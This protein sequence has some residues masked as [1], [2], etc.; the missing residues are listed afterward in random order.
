MNV[1]RWLGRMAVMAAAMLTAQGIP[2]LHAEPAASDFTGLE[3]SFYSQYGEAAIENIGLSGLS[4]D[5][6]GGKRI[7]LSTLA[8]V[9]DLQNAELTPTVLRGLKEG[10]LK[11]QTYHAVLTDENGIIA[12]YVLLRCDYYTKNSEFIQRR[13]NEDSGF[14]QYFDKEIADRFEIIT[15]KLTTGSSFDYRRNAQGLLSAAAG[16]NLAAGKTKARLVN[17][18][19]G[20]GYAILLTDGERDYLYLLDDT[21][22]MQEQGLAAK[23]I[24]SLQALTVTLSQNQGARSAW[25]EPLLGGAEPQGEGLPLT[26]TS[27][28]V[29]SWHTVLLIAGLLLLMASGGILLYLRVRRR[30]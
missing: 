29:M 22:P 17:L 2:A 20:L 19:D 15:M 4:R 12:G 23:S 3:K 13:A 1:K 6:L 25:G 28:A 8:P 14:L 5:A 18:V 21:R 24:I 11:T 10:E 30:S 27:A 26:T 7:L 9:Y 16:G